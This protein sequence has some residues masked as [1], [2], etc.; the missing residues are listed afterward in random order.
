MASDLME[1]ISS[2]NLFNYLLPGALLSFFTHPLI[3]I[4]FAAFHWIEVFFFI[5]FLGLL[6]SRLGAILVENIFK[7]FKICKFC[8]YE[9]Y[10]VAESQDSKLSILN[11]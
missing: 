10:C 2:Y 5:Y 7:Y 4:N 9:D 1:K 6:I 8:R 3:D 11:E